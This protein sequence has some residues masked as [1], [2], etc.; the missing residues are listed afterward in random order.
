MKVAVH[1]I[2]HTLGLPHC[3]TTGCLMEDAGGKVATV[4]G[5]FDLCERCRARLRDAG[6]AA[7]TV[8]P[9]WPRP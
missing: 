9:P 6:H 1:E 8:T 7:P 4:D 3:P 2:G 5:E